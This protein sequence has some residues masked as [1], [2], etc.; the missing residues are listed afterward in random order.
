MSPIFLKL[1]AFV[2][3][4]YTVML[5]L[6]MFGAGRVVKLEA[7]RLGWDKRASAWLVAKCTLLGLFG[8]HL[9]YAATRW[10]L[11][12]AAWWQMLL[13]PRY[14]H[15]WFGGFL[16]SWA[17][18]S[19]YARAHGIDRYRMYDVA[20]LAVLTAQPIGRLGCFFEGCCY[21][22]PTS[23]PWG[24]VMKHSEFG[25]S[26]LHP[27]QL[28]EALYLVLVF[29]ILWSRRRASVGTGRVAAAYLTL[30]PIGR[31][32]AEL[33]RGDTVRGFVLGRLSTSS[34]I[35]LLL[36][37]IGVWFW[38]RRL[39]VVAPQRSVNTAISGE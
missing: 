28:Y 21:G 33:F 15:V 34:F 18:C 7:A 38:S 8:A 16:A 37:P 31:I 13:D 22:R 29:L 12:G 30:A 23:L 9:L 27:V 2:V 20:A 26:A 14:G 17:Y 32:I 3:R 5:V 10:D 36:L 4:W 24:V 39:V 6:A 25:A 11:S 35:S 1:G 19:W